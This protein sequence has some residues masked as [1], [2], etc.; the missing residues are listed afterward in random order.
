MSGLLSVAPV[1]VVVASA[2]A[3]GARGRH[4]QPLPGALATFMSMLGKNTQPP[5]VLVWGWAAAS[6]VTILGNNTQ[7][8]EA[9]QVHT[10]GGVAPATFARE[11]APA[12]FMSMLGKNTQPPEVLVWGWA[13]ASFVTIL[14]KN[15]QTQAHTGAAETFASMCG[16]NTAGTAI[17]WWGASQSFVGISDKTTGT[18]ILW[19]GA[20]LLPKSFLC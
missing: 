14:G 2:Y 18:A 10:G 3:V 11:G 4:P 9:P 5:E 6:F 15:T 12:T 13:A 17:L 20:V 19:C 7:P 8:P 1:A 16:K